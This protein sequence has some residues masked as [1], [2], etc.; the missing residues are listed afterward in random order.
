MAKP[1]KIAKVEEIRERF[2]GH[3]VVLLTDFSGLKVDEINNLRFQLRDIGAEYRVLKNTL[4][5]LAVKDT[6]Y[7]EMGMFMEGPV[8]AAFVTG[9]PMAVAK[10]LVSYARANPNLVIKGG[11]M[12]GKILKA[13]DIRNLATM[14][15]REVLL[16]K[17]TGALKSPIYGLHSVLSG[18]YRKLVYTLQAVSETKSEAA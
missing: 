14:P 18:P 17:I 11:F 13:A 10:E 6:V 15:S 8:A 5:L 12:E 9:D 7:E 2:L 3:E 1:E 16:A 4:T